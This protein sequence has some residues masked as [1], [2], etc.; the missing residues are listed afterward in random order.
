[1]SLLLVKHTVINWSHYT[2]SVLSF[3]VL[4]HRVVSFGFR[5]SPPSN[6]TE[7]RPLSGTMEVRVDNIYTPRDFQR[8]PSG[9]IL[10]LHS[11]V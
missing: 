6:E 2:P 10:H 1:M 7:K 11:L 9:F 3:S 8:S 4:S 5:S